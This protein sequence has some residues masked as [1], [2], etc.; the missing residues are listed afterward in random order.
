[1]AGTSGL[2]PFELLGS[3][4]DEMVAA[5][6]MPAARRPGAEYRAWSSGHGLSMLL[7][8]GPLRTMA[9]AERAQVA[10]ALL[11]MVERGLA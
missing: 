5:G 7:I 6:V 9:A 11:G 4:L 8:D 3:V 2:N 1:M 10:E